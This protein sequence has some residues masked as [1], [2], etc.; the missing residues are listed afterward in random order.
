MFDSPTPLQHADVAN[1]DDETLE[2]CAQ[3][4]LA[5]SPHL[6]VMAELLAKLRASNF[7]WWSSTFTRSQWR[8]LPRMQWLAQRPDLRQRI[9]STLTGLPRKAARSK[10]PEFQAALIDAVVDHGDVTGAEFEEA[11][12]PQDLV[13]YGPL[14][15]MWAQ[16]RQR[17]PWFDDT[18]T[19]Q[20]FIGWLLRVLLNERSTLD[21]AMMR[22]P[23]LSAW[24]V[25][26]AIDPH[27]W[28]ERIPT[29]L[30][31]MVDDARL[32]REKA[33][34]REPYCARQELQ[35]VTPELIAQHLPLA[36]L[37]PVIHVAEQALFGPEERATTSL[38]SS[39]PMTAGE[40]QSPPPRTSSVN[41]LAIVGAPRPHAVAR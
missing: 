34:P 36:E 7:A 32:K 16:F 11:F 37:L 39:R 41:G 29:D 33:R 8:A 27:V 28:Q 19:N 13:T 38:E 10:T 20:R 22:K 18:E 14:A 4:H 24:E 15:E 3:A 2:R 25:R 12:A 21:P 5:S 30:R 35:I 31:A 23:I 9:T 17:M 6:Q 26:A 1:D 40:R